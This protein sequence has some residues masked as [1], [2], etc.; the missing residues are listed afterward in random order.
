MEP[1]DNE[2]NVLQTGNRLQIT[3]DIDAKGIKKMRDVLVKYEEI[4][5]LL[6]TKAKG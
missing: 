5:Q 4:L 1:V 6:A 2:I 3:A